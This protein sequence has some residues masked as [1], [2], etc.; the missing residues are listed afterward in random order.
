MKLFIY[1]LQTTACS[2]IFYA[3]YFL[4]LRRYT[5]FTL[6]RWYLL[7][8]LLLSLI[9]PAITFPVKQVAHMDMLQPVIYMQQMQVEKEPVTRVLKYNVDSTLAINWLQIV[10]GAYIVLAIISLLRFLSTLIVFAYRARSNSLMQIGNVQVIKSAGRMGNS[11]FFNVI[12]L[13]DDTLNADEVKQILAHE[14]LHVKLMHSLDRVLARFTQIVLWF[15][16]FV[17]AYI[18]SIEENH[19]F[20]VDRI[21]A[22]EADKSWYATL[23]FKLSVSNQSSLF[24]NFSKAPLKKR[25]AMLFNQPTNHMKKMMYL[26][27]LPVVVLSCLAFGR[28]NTDNVA[29]VNFKLLKSVNSERSQA[30]TVDINKFRQIDRLKGR[31]RKVQSPTTSEQYAQTADYKQKNAAVE[32]VSGKMLTYKVMSVFD[33][34][35]VM[36]HIIGYKVLHNNYSYILNTKYGQLKELKNQLKPGD[37]IEM[38]VFSAAYGNATPIVIEPALVIKN[39]IKLFQLAEADIIPKAPFLYEANRVRFTDGQV[40]KIQ[41]YPNGKWKSAVVEVVNG[42][43][44]K[45]NVK[46]SAP[47]FEDIEDGDHV[48]FRFVH[49]RKSGSKEYTV[50]D[51]VS[52][53]AN[54]KDYGTKNPDFFFKFY[55]K[56]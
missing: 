38:N 43:K 55:E 9:I 44:I 7:G 54:I 35:F 33:S 40:T 36:G 27:V 22:L 37:E 50:D 10:K 4:L 48:R 32:K 14:L 25:V 6:N 21:A 51:W 16:P 3:F 13:N 24:Q 41:K 53:S 11:S 34:S 1:L 23:L 19:E 29:K 2:G 8:T 45:F 28:L 20:E 46:P 42:Y 47:A 15:N 52:L 30:D 39:G 26:L 31:G 56:I 12:F 49:E 17:Y 5:F 18:R